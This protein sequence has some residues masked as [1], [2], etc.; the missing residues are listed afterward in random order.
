MPTSLNYCNPTARHKASTGTEGEPLVCFFKH[1]EVSVNNI[2]LRMRVI[3][4][5]KISTTSRKCRPNT[6]RIIFS[7]KVCIPPP[8]RLTVHRQRHLRK[9]FFVVVYR[10]Q[11]SNLTSEVHSEIGSVGHHHN[12]LT[13][14]TPQE[15]RR[16][17]DTHKLRFTVS[18]WDIDTY[19]VF[20]TLLNVHQHICE[21]AVVLAN[22]I[23]WLHPFTKLYEVIFGIVVTLPV[24]Q[25]ID[26]LINL[27]D[28]FRTKLI[29]VVQHSLYIFW[30]EV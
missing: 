2:L 20:I 8:R 4:K 13:G 18:G 28:L 1:R 17:K 25:L 30:R 11:V 14:V 12:L 27:C 22:L 6:T 16:E 9:Y 5:Q 10:Y 21:D 3:N 29:K 24:R 19:T 7:S 26:H 15:P 23:I